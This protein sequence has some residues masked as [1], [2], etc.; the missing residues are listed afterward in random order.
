MVSIYILLL[1]FVVRTVNLYQIHIERIVKDSDLWKNTMLPKLKVFY[2]KALLPELS[3]KG[4]FVESV[5]LAFVVL[6]LV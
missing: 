6:V 4:K 3:S 2:Y 1:D 5:N